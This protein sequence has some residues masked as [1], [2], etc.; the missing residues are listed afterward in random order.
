MKKLTL[1]AIAATIVAFGVQGQGLV[2]FVNSSAAGTKI[3]VNSAIGGGATG[4][5]PAVAGSFYYALF[6]SQ[7]LSTV[8]GSGASII[9]TLAG[10]GTYVWS[11]PVDWHFAGNGGPYTVNGTPFTS[12]GYATNVATAGRISGGAPD[13]VGGVA[14]GGSAY[15]TVV[16][17]SSNMGATWGAVQTLLSGGSLLPNMYLGESAVS[18]LLGTGDNFL[19][20]TPAIIQTSGSIPGW[21]LG[22]VNVTLIP[23]PT[24][25]ALAGLAGLSLLLFRR[26]K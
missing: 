13:A 17:W 16:G 14:A 7:T 23:E 15:F 18:P 2:N 25:M 11:D 5:T 21:T 6:Y 8:N 24:T 9:P 20:I 3:S 12:S 22:L 4:L 1:I 26:R 10:N 19:A